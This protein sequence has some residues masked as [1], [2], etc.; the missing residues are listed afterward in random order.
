M[1][2]R[3]EQ[4]PLTTEELD[5]ITADREEL[6]RCSPPEGLKVALLVR[7]E[8]LK[9]GIPTEAEV[10][11]ALRGLKGGREGGSLGIRTEDLR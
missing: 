1:Q 2:L 10:A 6:Y 11:E 9:D 8:D 7:K 4:A 5:K 3:E